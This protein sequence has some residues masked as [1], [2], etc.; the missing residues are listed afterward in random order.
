VCGL[1]ERGARQAGLVGG[2]LHEGDNRLLRRAVIPRRK[3]VHRRLRPRELPAATIVVAAKSI[4]RRQIPSARADLGWAIVNSPVRRCGAQKLV[5]QQRGKCGVT[6]QA[7]V[8]RR[9]FGMLDEGRALPRRMELPGPTSGA[10][11]S[12][13]SRR[14]TR[15]ELDANWLR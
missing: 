14:R 3:R 5:M 2:F 13:C 11:A 9:S 1:V 12:D 7:Q 15:I 6:H 4:D 8:P 10:G